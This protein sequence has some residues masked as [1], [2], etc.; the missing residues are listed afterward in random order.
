V[1]DTLTAIA[2]L[3]DAASPADHDHESDHASA[4][5]AVWTPPTWEEI[6]TQHSGRVY[7]LA[8]RTTRRISP[9]TS[10]SGCSG[11]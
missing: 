6:V 7:R 8:Y 1:T 4:D 11:H 2:G 9:T 10:S 3:K 5:L